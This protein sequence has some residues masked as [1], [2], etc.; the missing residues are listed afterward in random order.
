MGI[1]K[2]FPDHPWQQRMKQ[3]HW[4]A[5][6]EKIDLNAT[7]VELKRQSERARKVKKIIKIVL[8]LLGV[9]AFFVAGYYFYKGFL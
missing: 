8:I 5:P 7:D 1:P 6:V 4:F 3:G 9:A 2:G